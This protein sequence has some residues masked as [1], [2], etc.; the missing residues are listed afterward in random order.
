MA[1]GWIFILDFH[2][3]KIL[4]GVQVICN[5][6]FLMLWK[7]YEIANQS[8]PGGVKQ[9]SG[10][11]KH[12]LEGVRKNLGGFTPPPPANPPLQKIHP[13]NGQEF[14]SITS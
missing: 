14:I 13:W 10:G 7:G 3:G 12:F 2:C 11:V 5:M 1:Q 8:A 6:P 4:G 9:N